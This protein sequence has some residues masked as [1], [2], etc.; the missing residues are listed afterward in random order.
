MPHTIELEI[1]EFNLSLQIVSGDYENQSLNNSNNNNNNIINSNSN[2]NN[3]NLI[4]SIKILNSKVW[5]YCRFVFINLILFNC[6]ILLL[7]I[8]FI[9]FIL[10]FIYFTNSFI[11]FFF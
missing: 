11:Y 8:F 3:N 10:F 9:F 5:D 1:P 4:P 6:F 2:N 7:I